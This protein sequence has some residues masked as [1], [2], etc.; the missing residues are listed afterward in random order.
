[1][2]DADRDSVSAW[3]WIVVLCLAMT[4]SAAQQ[5]RL[6]VSVIDDLDRPVQGATVRVVLEE[7]EDVVASA[8]SDGLG[9]VS[10]DIPPQRS[11]R[12][13]VSLYGYECPGGDAFLRPV[14]GETGVR[15]RLRPVEP[16]PMLERPEDAERPRRG[17][18]EGTLLDAE[19]AP[20]ANVPVEARNYSSFRATRSGRDGRY[21]LVLP[22][23]TYSV[24]SP[25]VTSAPLQLREVSTF[26]AYEPSADNHEIVVR[27]DRLTRGVDLRLRALP[28]FNV[29]ITVV[30]SAGATVSDAEVRF[31]Y[32]RNFRIPHT[33]TGTLTTSKDGTV[34]LGPLSPGRVTVIAKAGSDG[35][36]LAGTAAIEVTDRPEA[37][38]VTLLPAARLT[39]RVEFIDRAVPLH[40]GRGLRVLTR[41]PDSVVPAYA[42]T[43]ADGVVDAAGNFELPALAGAQC[44]HI[45]G[46][47]LGW[48]LADIT[49]AGRDITGHPLTF[50]SGTVTTDV[51]IRVEQGD[52][53]LRSHPACVP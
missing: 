9:L 31:S 21:R 35:A 29:T 30:T 39:G 43:D 23:G 41:S 53:T 34:R 24:A 40:G 5:S 44:L 18:I 51:L 22:P 45:E 36:R 46:L 28:L 48:R 8:V 20:V 49:H 15:L 50:D 16:V 14:P 3:P 32:R 13:N 12:I 42:N 1:M 25:G 38:L 47:P 4:A 10:L 33:Y 7:A 2:V 17:V 26:V 52:S 19:G 37:A 6:L 11:Y 27:A